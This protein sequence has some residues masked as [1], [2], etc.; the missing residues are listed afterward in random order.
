VKVDRTLF[1]EIQALRLSQPGLAT[2]GRSGDRRS[3]YRGRGMEFADHRPY[4]PGD[5]LRLVD[6][7]V[8][9]RL[10]QVLVRLFHEDR[11]LCM[12]IC[13]DASASMGHGSP[14][15]VEHAGSL[16]GALA[17]MGLFHRDTVTLAVASDRPVHRVRGHDARALG[18]VLRVLE[19]TEAAGRPDLAAAVRGLTGRHRLDRL[20]VLTDLLVEDDEREA[21]LRAMASS[22]RHPVLMHVLD[23]TELSPD[24]SDGVE[25]EDAETGEVI[26]VGGSATLAASYRDALEGWLSDIRDRCAALQI[27]YVSA[28]TTVPVRD[29]VFD[30]LRSGRI[31][32]S[33]RGGAR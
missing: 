20:V 9:A 16:A 3:P 10:G 32:E 25:A 15:K 30:A 29:L 2:G 21:V 13:L 14:V 27:L 7:N 24:L 31:I 4:S 6:W 23:A 28:Y 18:Q 22:C 12:G 33:S 8:Y 19:D 26:R 5:D 17:A 11:N 1:A